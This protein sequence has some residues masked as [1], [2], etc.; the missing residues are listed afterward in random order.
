MP[1]LLCPFS[2]ARREE[3]HRRRQRE[4]LLLHRL[5]DRAFRGSYFHERNAQQSAVVFSQ[6]NLRRPPSLPALSHRLVSLYKC[7]DS[8]W[9]WHSSPSDSRSSH[10]WSGR[11][12]PALEISESAATDDDEGSHRE[13]CFAA[14]DE[15]ETAEESCSPPGTGA[16]ADGGALETAARGS[17][18]GNSGWGGSAAVD[19]ESLLGDTVLLGVA[20]GLKDFMVHTSLC[21][22]DGLGLEGQSASFTTAAME[23]CGFGVDHLALVWCKQLI[24]R[25]VFSVFVCVLSIIFCS[26]RKRLC[27]TD[28]KAMSCTD[29]YL[30]R[31]TFCCSCL[32]ILSSHLSCLV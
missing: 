13:A 22:T 4:H 25:W 18:V 24:G 8:L 19:A 27:P 3:K 15:S 31:V 12:G 7:T 10:C 6:R 20:G 16:L 14:G 21:E 1:L 30:P 17:V 5:I 26:F 32:A 9:R 11:N 29:I 23:E 2:T 28:V